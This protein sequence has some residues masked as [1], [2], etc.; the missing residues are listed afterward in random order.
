MPSK[1]SLDKP[2]ESARDL[3]SPAQLLKHEAAGDQKTSPRQKGQPTAEQQLGRQGSGTGDP[4]SPPLSGSEAKSEPARKRKTTRSAE[5]DRKSDA[6][7]EHNA[8]GQVSCVRY[9]DGHQIR[10]DYASGGQLNRFQYSDGSA[11]KRQGQ[12]WM[13]YDKDGRITAERMRQARIEVGKQGSFVVEQADG[14]R[15]F[16]RPDGAI[17]SQRANGSL[18]ER[19]RNGRLTKVRYPDGKSREF[20][21]GPGGELNQCRNADGSTWKKDGED[22]RLFD[23]Q[24]VPRGDSQAKHQIRVD[25]QGDFIFEHANG[26]RTIT[27]P[28]GSVVSE[29]TDGSW[30]EHN[31]ASQVTRIRYPDGQLREFAYAA[32]GKL[33]KC[34]LADG[35]LWR[36]D[37]DAWRLYDRDGHRTGET[38]GSGKM[39]VDRQGNLTIERSNGKRTITRPDGKVENK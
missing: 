24:G 32:D 1:D 19:N 2:G 31:R 36:N 21:Y 4:D 7:V 39:D 29:N 18:I 20:A 25:Q 16:T 6:G 37:G 15:T 10:F 27:R 34:R 35:T 28:D 26:N 5:L 14:S 17:V 13:L 22:W 30:L 12:A 8:D 38:L 9:P 33:I 11:W 3:E 23:Q